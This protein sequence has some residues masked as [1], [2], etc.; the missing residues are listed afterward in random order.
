MSLS[1]I[2]TL[3]KL[4]I[5]TNSYIAA[6]QA[7]GA[8]RGS[9]DQ[10]K[11]DELI[12]Q[13]TGE[14]FQSGSYPLAQM[15]F[16]YLVQEIVRLDLQDQIL[17]MDLIFDA[18]NE[19]AVEFVATQPWH[20]PDD[21]ADGRVCRLD[22]VRRFID[23]FE[24]PSRE[25]LI[26]RLSQD[27]EVTKATVQ[28]WL[29]QIDAEDNFQ[30]YEAEDT[31]APKKAEP[32]IRI[33]KGN[34]AIKIVERIYDGNNKAAVIDAIASEL[35]TTR[36]GA[37]TFF[38]AAVKKLQLSVVKPEK[39]EAKETTQD[40]L[41]AII[42]NEPTIDRKGFIEKAGEL[43]VKATTAQTYYYALTASMG[44][45]RQGT[46]QRGRKKGDGVSRI[47]QVTAFVEK[48]RAFPKQAL[49][50]KLSEEFTVSKVSAQS[51][52]YAALKILNNKGTE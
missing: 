15:L 26:E 6:A 43:G 20:W 12:G 25:V 10:A 31:P 23:L 51:Y 19:K 9:C 13:I 8:M 44:V 27:F 49:L 36:G 38:Y 41:K 52:Y 30:E 40:R 11:Y 29:R 37:Q 50:N 22:E 33:N 21:L 46:G 42:E 5:P 34:E 47:E 3:Q 4:G 7:A 24:N 28:G 16:G 45:E 18:A 14:P 39:A 2:S 32:K 1:P 48:H 35:S 17:D